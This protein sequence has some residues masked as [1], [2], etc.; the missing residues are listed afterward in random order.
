[1]GRMVHR[2]SG[3]YTWG[4]CCER[5]KATDATEKINKC[6]RL[7]IPIREGFNNRMG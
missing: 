5:W 7:R 4:I 6:I 2:A 3:R 1:M